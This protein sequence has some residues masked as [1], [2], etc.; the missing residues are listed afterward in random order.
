[1]EDG[2]AGSSATSSMNLPYNSLSFVHDKDVR[3]ASGAKLT[4]V[5][6]DLAH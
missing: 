6:G 2:A 1:M 4:I 3:M 5:V